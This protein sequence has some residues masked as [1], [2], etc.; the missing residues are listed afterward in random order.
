MKLLG[1][2][3]IQLMR[4]SMI[5]RVFFSFILAGIFAFPLFSSE[6]ILSPE[7]FLGHPVGADRKLADWEQVSNYF[8]L[9]GKKS[10]FVKVQVIGKSTLGKDM[11]MAVISSP[12]NLSKINEIKTAQ[13]EL[14]YCENLSL[15]EALALIEKTPTVLMI[16]MNIHSTEIA[17]SQE[18]LELLYEWTVN[19]SDKMKEILKNLV[20]LLIPSVNPDGL[21]MVTDWYRQ[22]V[23]TENEACPMPKLYHHYAGHDDNRDWFMFALS[24]SKVVTNQYYKEWF[25]EIILDQHQM[26]NTGPRLF[27]PPYIDPVNPNVHP[28]VYSQLNSIGN[29]IVNNLTEQ[30]LKGVASGTYFSGWWQGA[31]IMTP[32]WHNQIGI[33]SEMAGC[34]VATPLYVDKT[35]LSSSGWGLSEYEQRMNFLSPWEGGWWRLRDIIDYEKAMTYSLLEIVAKQRKNIKENY[36]YM[37][38]DNIKKG[39]SGKP[40]AYVIPEEQTDPSGMIKMLGS[41]KTGGVIVERAVKEF[42]VNNKTY[43]SGTYVIKMSQPFRGYIKDLMEPQTY[44]EIKDCPTCEPRKPYDGTAWTLPYQMG[45]FVDEISKPFDVETKV[46]DFLPQSGSIFGDGDYYLIDHRYNT[47]FTALNRLLDKGVDVNWLTDRVSR[48]QRDLPAGMMIVEKNSK[49]QSI[50]SETVKDCFLNIYGVHELSDTNSLKISKPEIAIYQSYFPNSDEGWIRCVM[51]TFE[52]D[53]DTLHNEEMKSDLKNYDVLILPPTDKGM[54]EK[55]ESDWYKDAPP[56]PEKY[57]GGIGEEGIEQLKKFVKEGGTLICFNESADLAVELFNLPALNV[58]K[59]NKSGFSAPG[60]IIRGE[61][62][63]NHPMGFGMPEKA[64]LYYTG[65]PVFRLKPYTEKLWSVVKFPKTDLRLSGYIKGDK[66]I[67]GKA[68]AVDIPYSKGRV[69]MFGFKPFNRAQSWGTFK[70][71][72]NSLYY[73]SAEKI[74]IAD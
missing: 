17:S 21:Q 3:E 37:N 54:L 49:T 67:Q 72:L 73:P 57:T 43:S 40:F 6:K 14:T 70:L 61:V 38:I 68:G 45:I 63:N 2:W 36:Y 31:S 32:F 48:G 47:S 35:A 15:K 52:V 16:T 42:S 20:I 59:D 8:M 1:C 41:L 13:K 74:V 10:D 53:Y 23:G 28:L 33:L 24:E 62:D 51:D 50:L 71:F 55:G 27:V 46:V 64:A 11:I 4:I 5:K 58:V 29:Q 65:G 25:P 30:G 18:S 44:P 39:L 60:C 7:E 12:E 22:H 56:K 9:L 26:W 69:I 19:P 34:L 66:L